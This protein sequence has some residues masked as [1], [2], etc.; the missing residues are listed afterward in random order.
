MS[1]ENLIQ[2]ALAAG[3]VLVSGVG[4]YYAALGGVRV[5]IAKITTEIEW[6][7]QSRLERDKEQDQKH[8]RLDS[9]IRALENPGYRSA[10]YREQE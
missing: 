7:K 6:L 5:A 9:R 4:A 10:R 8:D 2:L 3:T 1:A